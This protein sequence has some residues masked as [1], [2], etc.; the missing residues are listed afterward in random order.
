MASNDLSAF[1]FG[2]TRQW[3]KNSCSPIRSDRATG[4][5]PGV[6]IGIAAFV[7]THLHYHTCILY[8]PSYSLKP[9]LPTRCAK[10]LPFP[11]HFRRSKG[12]RLATAHSNLI[13]FY[14][15]VLCK[16][17][18][19]QLMLLSSHACL[20]RK[21]ICTNIYAK[22]VKCVIMFFSV[23]TSSFCFLYFIVSVLQTRRH[24]LV[25]HVQNVRP[26][27]LK[28]DLCSCQCLPVNQY[29]NYM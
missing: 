21:P 1:T 25:R 3:H 24:D 6:D 20:T 10:D 13:S 5:R 16:F 11:F 17:L 27:P 23:Y 29:D 19:K 22:C 7:M 2:K 28:A 4:T 12:R 15:I 9:L 18:S 14:C 8:P 26:P